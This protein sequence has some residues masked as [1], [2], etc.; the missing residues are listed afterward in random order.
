[1]GAI[2]EVGQD[3]KRMEAA[4]AAYRQARATTSSEE[5]Y[6]RLDGELGER[7]E[8]SQLM[9]LK[10]IHKIL[11]AVAVVAAVGMFLLN[12]WMGAAT[13]RALETGAPPAAAAN[14]P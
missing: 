12:W 5:E 8:R 3:P 2:R 11:T 1:M 9:K 13:P 4:R 10:R 7:E 6:R 14:S